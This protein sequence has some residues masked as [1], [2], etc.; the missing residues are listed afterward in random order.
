MSGESV[1]ATNY[2][3][4][5]ENISHVLDDTRKICQYVTT[6]E[7]MFELKHFI[8]GLYANDT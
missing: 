5:P 4:E 1:T 6:A 8:I 2:V 3:N 7:S